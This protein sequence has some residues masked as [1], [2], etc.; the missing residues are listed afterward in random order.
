MKFTCKVKVPDELTEELLPQS[1]IRL[2]GSVDDDPERKYRGMS[3]N[4]RLTTNAIYTSGHLFQPDPNLDQLMKTRFLLKDHYVDVV[5]NRQMR[6]SGRVTTKYDP[7]VLE[8]SWR[9][10]G[11]L[12]DDHNVTHTANATRL[13]VLR[14]LFPFDDPIY[15]TEFKGA[16]CARVILQIIKEVGTIQDKLMDAV[17]MCD[18]TAASPQCYK[19]AAWV[20]RSAA[21]MARYCAELQPRCAKSDAEDFRG[22]FRCS[23]RLEGLSW[24]L[25]SF[26]SSVSKAQRICEDGE[27]K[28]PLLDFGACVG[29]ALSATGY[30][31]ASA[32]LLE[33]AL[34]FD[35]PGNTRDREE[36]PS[37]EPK[38][39]PESLRLTCAR[40]STAIF[41]TTF[42]AGSKAVRAAGHCGG[43]DTLC[44]RSI[45][46]SAAALSGVAENGVFL[47]VW[48][49][50]RTKCCQ[51]NPDTVKVECE[52]SDRDLIELAR[53]DANDQKQCARFWLANEGA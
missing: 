6:K 15:D 41:R 13:A 51:L 1:R 43:T 29:E 24:S 50:G 10:Q 28:S 40:D 21:S 38:F 33:S 32:L 45:L 39:I 47:R 34:G 35:C 14:R 2:G 53:D 17:P 11:F 9:A 52:C 18:P 31:F 44:G 26:S 5:T 4:V 23:E 25:D 8:E 27:L 49:H 46:R 20:V 37:Q 48:C 12:D 36:N 3:S 30:M 7:D 19:A 16:F 22:D 42:L